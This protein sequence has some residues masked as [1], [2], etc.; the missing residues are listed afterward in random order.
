M[1]NTQLLIGD[2]AE[3]PLPR[4]TTLSEI[5]KGFSIYGSATATTMRAAK[6]RDRVV[7]RIRRRHYLGVW[8]SEVRRSC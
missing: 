7:V 8:E 5:G 3:L 1:G 6:D 2:V 4:E